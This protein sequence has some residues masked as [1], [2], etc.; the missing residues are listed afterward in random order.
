MKKYIIVP[1]QI[2]AIALATIL[3]VFVPGACKSDASGPQVLG[4]DSAEV[5]F[6]EGDSVYY[7]YAG[8]ECT[9][10]V[11]DFIQPGNDPV[12]YQIL[13]ARQNGNVIGNFLTGDRVAVVVSSDKKHVVRAIDMSSLIGQWLTGDSIGDPAA[14]GFNL[15]E[16]GYASTISSQP[17]K[18]RYRRW[19]IRSAR[20]V[21]TKND[22]MVPHPVN[23]YDTFNIIS[24]EQDTLVLRLRHTT[25]K[26]KYVKKPAVGKRGNNE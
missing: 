10:S 22:P 2:I 16:D 20:L 21:L 13:E 1:V 9:D 15:G 24:L 11:L 4:G 7:G 3:G 8:A 26:V 12:H 25:E 23:D 14:H 5:S 19:D 6:S 18:M 17:V